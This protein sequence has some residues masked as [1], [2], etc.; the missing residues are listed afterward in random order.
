MADYAKLFI[1]RERIC[2]P[3]QYHLF[4]KTLAYAP[5]LEYL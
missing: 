4:A 5:R 2:E 1:P 3:I